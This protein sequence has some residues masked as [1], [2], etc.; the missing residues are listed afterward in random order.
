VGNVGVVLGFSEKRGDFVIAPAANFCYIEFNAIFSMNEEGRMPQLRLELLGRFRVSLGGMP[1]TTFESNKVRALLAYLAVESHH[2][3]SRE[4]LAALLWPDWPNSAALSNLR[5]A[6]SDL[7]KVIGDRTADPAF[8]LITREA[9][10]FNTES[11]HSLDVAQFIELTSTGDG[12]EIGRL[13]QAVS[14]YQGEFMEGFSVSEAAPFEDWARLKGEQFQ[15]VYLQA[16]H[17]LAAALEVRGEFERALPYARRQIEVEPLDESAYRQLMRLLAL[18]GRGGEALAQYETC[19][20]VLKKELGAEPS[21][22][23]EDLYQLLLKGELP[24]T[25]PSE[26]L[27]PE[28]VARQV[29]FCPY[30]GLATFRE[31]DA[32]FFFGRE[33][34]THRLEETI[35]RGSPIAVIVGSSGSGKSSVVYAGLLP[36]LRLK[37]D[38]QIASF[39]PGE[40]P[41][42]ALAG[43][44]LPLLEPDTKETD[45]L[46]QAGK[47]ATALSQEEV[48]LV[49]IARRATQMKEFTRHML[50]VVDQFEEIYTLCTDPDERQRFLDQL[51]GI[52]E[53]GNA[54]SNQR[55][56]VL[57]TLRADFMGQA[58]AYRPFADV[59][60]HTS[61]LLGPMNRDELRSA[62]EKPA[63]LQ[64]AVFEAGLVDRLL[65]D[66]GN[67]PG[68]LPLLEFALTL[69]WEHQDNG[70]LTHA[71]YDSIGLVDGA[72]ASYADQVFGSLEPRDQERA[73]S[74]LLQLVKPG[75]GTEDTRR[76]AAKEE[77]GE[78]N[79]KVIQLLADQRLVVTNLD[80]AG[81]ESAEVV[82]ETLIQKWGRFKEWLEA[83]RT[84]RIW[85]EQLRLNLRQWQESGREE[86][87]LLSGGRLSIANEWLA[88]RSG[89]LSQ[90]GKEYILASQAEQQAKQEAESAQQK[91]EAALTR[92]SRNFLFALVVI[93]LLAVIGTSGLAY[94]TRRAQVEAEAQSQARATQQALA[95]GE[96]AARGTQQAIAE[97]ERANAQAQAITRATAE[98]DALRQADLARAR[99]LSLAAINNLEADPERSIL[100]GLQSAS[101]Y[102]SIGKSL[103]NDLQSTLHQAIQASRARLTWEAGEESILSSGFSQPGDLPRV[104]TA[105]SG[106]GT[107]TL[108]D[109]G[110]N[111]KL[112]EIPVPS[113]DRIEAS[114]SSDGRIVAVSEGK[115]V[116]LWDV[117]A[118]REY[119]R[120]PGY[121]SE[122]RGLSFSP[123]SQF[124]LTQGVT[125]YTIREIKTGN[126]IL[127]FPSPAGDRLVAVF[128]PDGKLVA[129]RTPDNTISIF[130]IT[131][132]QALTTISLDPNFD[133][134]A[135]AFNP[136]GIH[137][138][139]A[140]RVIECL[141]WDVQTGE[142]RLSFDISQGPF[143]AGQIEALAYSPDGR[144]LALPGV[145]YDAVKGEELFY[146][147]GHTKGVSSLTFNSEGTRLIT[148]SYDQTVKT[149][150]LTPSSEVLTISNP[151]GSFIYG[152]AFSPDGKWLVTTGADKTAQVWELASGKL[153]QILEGHTDF[154]NSIAFSP[155]GALLATGSADRS[156]RVWDT[157]TWQTTQVLRGHA[158]DKPGIVPVIRGVVAVAFSPQCTSTPG[159]PNTCPLAGV[160]MDGQLIVWDALT[161]QRL[162]NY[163]DPD[164]GLKSVAFSPD[165]ELV[166]VGSTGVLIS[167]R[168]AVTILD[169]G[170]GNVLHNFPGEPG[171]TWGIAFSPDGSRLATIHFYGLVKVWGLATYETQFSL[172]EVQ[173]GNSLVFDPTGTYLATAGSGPIAVWDAHSGELLLNLSGHE[174]VPIFGIAFSSDGKYLATASFDGTAR[175]FVIPPDDLLALGRARLTRGFTLEECRQYLHLEQCPED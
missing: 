91:R 88:E 123:D 6:L 113:S 144:Q 90:A 51:L 24:P 163:Q 10:Q 139:G 15:R 33:Q 27:H 30:R 107:V 161:G 26:L 45:R 167:P 129:A 158:E 151:S 175:V 165:G 130:D 78:E 69:L 4:K 40:R 31:Q 145:I 85:Q 93:L 72:L 114:L 142:I 42:G 56:I 133:V 2:P 100:L 108:W 152:V 79:W 166:A 82:H 104:L 53:A 147:P 23:T 1:I 171:W 84:F 57:L 13:E 96:A 135:L 37:G 159:A 125:T 127:E 62:V 11:D 162:Y 150:D 154:V 120:L 38:W 140:G 36:K 89:D 43:A 134:I 63:E 48:S 39:R 35:Q 86:S 174:A 143:P 71:V 103:P 173:S 148:A 59:L 34:F 136:D 18:S 12:D 153:V 25:L 138:A 44:L 126:T 20:G 67:E 87:A 92:R 19:R 68:N 66:V 58:L 97:A 61:M 98:A 157:R 156:V 75:E 164:G 65:D 116:G 21:P 137:L 54:Q 73:R 55:C 29:G 5:Y 76:M 3:H 22:E 8:L 99:E 95:E 168:G 74:A 160:G 132:G 60:Q 121:T 52:V 119:Q 128:S 149:W 102:I 169:A 64:G 80:A 47:L 46:I 155:D 106:K 41:F 83:D 77:L 110:V 170:N 9:I 122:I 118:G 14:L 7:R 32:Q 131:T 146:L 49:G 50:L 109:P 112:L 94:I 115:E 117:G 105:N 28:R 141:V 124:L 70:W 101:I 17:K 81:N 111:Q 16:L 172:T